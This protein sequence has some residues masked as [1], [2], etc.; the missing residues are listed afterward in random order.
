M[1]S[2]VYIIRR[3]LFRSISKLAPTIEGDILDFGCG[4]KPYESLFVNSKS[5]T[6]V[7]IEASGHNHK[8]SKVDYFYDGKTLPFPDQSFDAVVCFEVFEHVFNID[9]MLAEVS[10]VL[11]PNGKLLMSIPFAWDEHEAP[12]D[13]ARYTSYGIKHLVNKSGFEVVSLEKTTTYVL[14]VFQM[15]AAYLFQHALPK[16]RI[17]GRLSQLALIFPLNLSAVLLNIVL[18]KRYEYFC[19]NV[20][21]ARKTTS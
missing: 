9:E 8:D 3:G 7:D 20:V 4:S 18:P 14:A 19:N 1:I 5:Y 2:P 11:K 17:L 13:F 16:G 15:F 10:R 6:G 21:L 12:Y